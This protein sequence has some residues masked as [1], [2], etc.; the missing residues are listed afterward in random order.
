M[1]RCPKCGHEQ[2]Q[3]LE[4]KACGLLFQKY[5][6]SRERRHQETAGEVDPAA[7]RR[8]GSLP[9][10]LAAVLLVAVT[11]G[12]T[13]WLTSGRPTG[14]TGSAP[15]PVADQGGERPTLPAPEPLAPVHSPAA[16]PATVAA[17][18]IEQAKSGTVAIETPWGKG[19]GF[20]L[21]DTTVVTN[22][23][24]IEPDRAQLAELRRKVTTGRQLIDLERRK[25]DEARG[26]L[27]RLPDSPSRRQLVIVLQEREREL[28]GV[29]P[30]QAEAEARLARMEQAATNADIRVF[31]A[32]GSEF[33]AQSIQTSPSRDLALVTV[34]SAGATPLR[35]APQ[36]A[37]PQQGDRVYTIGNPVGLRNTVTAGIFSGYRRH[38]ESGEIYLQTDA[39]IN[40]GNSGG[41]LID[42]RGRVLGINTMIVHNTEGIGFA[43]PVTT[44]FE[45][46]SLVPTPEGD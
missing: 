33:T 22:K 32:D 23:H 30:A 20:F 45:E 34:Y 13:W 24:V 43:I 7:P 19:S 37:G 18:P 25:L 3:Q 11:A 38:E 14:Q 15:V 40:P 5:T 44:V 21:T 36:Q 12:T 35:P 26:Q 46:F 17:S 4:C 27:R 8:S 39:A 16:R 2:E 42:E 28:A 6:Q 9:L 1:I 41:P 29:L 10:L 31:L